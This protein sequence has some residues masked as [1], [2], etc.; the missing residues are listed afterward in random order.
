[1]NRIVIMVVTALGLAALLYAVSNKDSIMGSDSQNFNQD[2][3]SKLIGLPNNTKDLEKNMNGY[4]EIYLAGGCFWGVEKY[5]AKINGVVSTDVGYANGKTQNP[6]YQD[7]VYRNT[8]HAE[9]VHIV[10]DPNVVSLPFLLSMYYKIIDPTSVNKQGN[11]RG[12]QYRTGIYFTKAQDEQIARDSLLNL[13]KEYKG[14]SI[15]IELL[16]LTNY[17]KAEE[18][19]QK[20]LDKNPNGYC[21]IGEDK[22]ELASNAVDN[23]VS[24]ILGANKSNAILKASSTPKSY[25][26][27]SDNEL[28]DRLTDMQYNVTQ[29]N[30][31]EPAFRNA[32]WNNYA[33][34]IYVDI[35]TGE[36]LFSSRDKFDSGSGWPSFTKP[37]AGTNIKEHLDKSYGMVRTEVR[38]EVGNAHLG[39]L[40]NDGPKDKGGMRY[41]IN[42]A[43]LRFIPKENMEE[44]GYGHLI[45]L[46]E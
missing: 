37:I 39:H 24:K 26:L 19:H 16:P 40:F 14:R 27:L 12:T 7:V 30:A 9:T 28:R 10:Y 23:S 25:K 15:A 36:P 11:D 18:Y 41:C 33:D 46:F 35:T 32:Y 43:S 22:F 38:S 31:T 4:E 3:K 34:G 1:M 42:S 29:K 20:Y 6:S 44:E 17:Y 8:N 5:F 45:Y 21:H 13:S 2:A